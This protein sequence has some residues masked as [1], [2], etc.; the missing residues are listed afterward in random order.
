M[1][2]D[3]RLRLEDM[4]EC[5]VKII[6]YTSDLSKDGFSKDEKTYD[7]VLRNLEIIGEAA[8]QV[9]DH[10]RRAM[11]SIEWRQIAGMRD[12]VA[13]GYFGLDRNMIWDTVKSDVPTLLGEIEKFIGNPDGL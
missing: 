2:R 9:P 8:K 3:W 11:A 4:R 13:H 12:W 10:A 7:A 6:E 1:S 5:C